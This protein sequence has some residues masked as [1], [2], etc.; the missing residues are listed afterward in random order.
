MKRFMILLAFVQVVFASNLHCDNCA[1]KVKENISFEKG[2][3]DLSVS[4]EDNTVT[5]VFNPSKTDTLKLKKAINKLGYK[6]EVVEY[7]TIK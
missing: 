7:K 5:V 2:V 1:K 4:V 6:A 3:K